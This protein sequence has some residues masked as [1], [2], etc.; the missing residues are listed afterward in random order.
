MIEPT[1]SEL[2]AEVDRFCDAMISIREEIGMVERGGALSA[3]QPARERA[4]YRRVTRER[5]LAPPLLASG[6]RLSALN[7]WASEIRAAGQPHRRACRRS[8]PGMRVPTG[9]PVLRLK[10]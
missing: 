2:K 3:G 5:R 4:A 7:G 9:I 10:A 1:E 8:Q 6:G